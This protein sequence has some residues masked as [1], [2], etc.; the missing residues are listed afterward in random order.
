MM[1]SKFQLICLTALV[2][3]LSACK[4][5]QGIGSNILPDTDNLGF[6]F[7]D[8]T[9][10]FVQTI[11]ESPLRSDRMLYNYLGYLESTAFGSS[12]ANT[13]IEL[14]RPQTVPSDSL[15]PFTLESVSLN[16]VYDNYYG[17]TTV[18]V[19]IEVFQL[20]SLIDK[21]IVYNADYNFNTSMIP[22]GRA[23]SYLYKP[24]TLV[25]LTADDTTS[26]TKGLLKIPMEN[27]FGY[28]LLNQIKTKTYN[29]DSLFKL[30]LPGLKV[31]VSNASKG[32]AMIQFN[33]SDAKCGLNVYA[34]NKKGDKF[35][36][37]FPISPSLFYHSK[38]EHNYLGSLV[39]SSLNSIQ[40][41]DEKCYLQSQS[42]TKVWVKFGNVEKFR[43]ALINKAVIEVVELN[44]TDNN[45]PKPR[46]IFP[47]KRTFDGGNTSLEDYSSNLF[48]PAPLDTTKTRED[49][50]KIVKYQIN[51]S[52]YFQDF[53][54]GKQDTFGIHLT[55]YPLF[56]QTPGFVLQTGT[57]VLSNY[58]EPSTII[59][60]GPKNGDITRRMKLKV[61]YTLP[62]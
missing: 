48:G 20:Q 19:D 51:I 36:L 28:A 18:P 43:N 17:D 49:G 13:V 2:L 33:L 52:N 30:Y 44:A 39:G 24:N 1:P 40:A 56:S 14:V 53:V 46:S 60:A 25:K 59:L 16:L 61:W 9:E 57:I 37:F 8:S 38:F 47:L 31:A 23:S 50:S 5:D 3:L 6:L 15:A 7:D 11:K 22:V 54:L 4:K 29:T 12:T 10:L 21:S 41:G 35:T 62:K 27:Y 55:N 26:G 34:R 58:V 32:K 42:G 45:T